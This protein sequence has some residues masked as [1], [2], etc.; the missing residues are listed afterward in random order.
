M[1]NMLRLQ[2]MLTIEMTGQMGMQFESDNVYV[3]AD[4]T[5]LL[6]S[7]CCLAT[8]QLCHGDKPLRPSLPSSVKYI[9]Y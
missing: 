5:P 6:P 8:V 2:C 9:T 1:C 7:C 4:R 3:R